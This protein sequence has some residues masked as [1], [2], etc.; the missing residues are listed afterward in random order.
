MNYRDFLL[1]SCCVSCF[2]MSSNISWMTP[3]APM[4]TGTIV[5]LSTCQTGSAHNWGLGSSRFFR[6]FYL[7]CCGLKEQ[8]CLWQSRGA[9]FFPPTRYRCVVPGDLAQAR[10]L[11]HDRDHIT[12]FGHSR[13]GCVFLQ[14]AFVR[15]YTSCRDVT[16]LVNAIGLSSLK[17]QIVLYAFPHKVLATAFSWMAHM[18]ASV[19]LFNLESQS[20][21][22]ERFLLF[23]GSSSSWSFWPCISLTESCCFFCSI[24]FFFC[25]FFTL[26]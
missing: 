25:W 18:A 15:I 1:E 21:A 9:R 10:S 20:Y 24:H 3:I 8:L 5:S 11:L 2:S 13:G 16:Y 22:V 6:P 12:P 14:V 23:C 7:E 26:L 4:L 17:K 19:G